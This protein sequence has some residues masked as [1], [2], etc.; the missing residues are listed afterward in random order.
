MYFI[1]LKHHVI[2]IINSF[3]L[4]A[5]QMQKRNMHYISTPEAVYYVHILDTFTQGEVED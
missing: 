2:I 1:I 5:N 3:V 4:H